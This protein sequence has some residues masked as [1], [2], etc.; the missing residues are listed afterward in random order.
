M[1][2]LRVYDADN[3]KTYSGIHVKCLDIFVKIYPDFH[4]KNSVTNSTEIR[5]G[6]S[7]ADT[8]RKNGQTKGLTKL[9]GDFRE[10]AR[11]PKSS[12]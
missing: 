4:T 10:Y 9:I 6:K 2:L 7:R 11:T 12:T 5:P 8:Y 1:L 3:N